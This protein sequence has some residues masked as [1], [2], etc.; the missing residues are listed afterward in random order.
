MTYFILLPQKPSLFMTSLISLQTRD[1]N[2]RDQTFERRTAF[3]SSFF[4]F[5]ISSPSIGLRTSSVRLHFTSPLSSGEKPPPPPLPPS[6]PPPPPP[7][8]DLPSY[9]K[10][11]QFLFYFIGSFLRCGHSQNRPR[12]LWLVIIVRYKRENESG[13]VDVKHYVYLLR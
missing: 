3:F 2:K 11:I 9:P 5:F 6:P 8:A 13:A 10:S 7:P 12:V 4:F 1:F